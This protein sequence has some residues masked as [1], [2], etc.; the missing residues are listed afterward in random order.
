MHFKQL[1]PYLDKMKIL[2]CEAAKRSAGVAPEENLR[3]PL[4]AGFE[5]HEVQSR[6]ISDPP[7]AMLVRSKR[8]HEFLC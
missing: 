1:E 3:N 8:T 6:G 7:E 4:H 2:N 5:T